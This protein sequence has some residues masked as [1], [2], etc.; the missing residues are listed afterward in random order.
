MPSADIDA[1]CLID[2]L[3]SGH[4]EAILQACGYT[5]YL[6]VAVQSEVLYIRQ[7]D[8]AQAGKL[9]LVE[10]DLNPLLKSGALSLC[11][12]YNDQEMDRF[13]QY[14]TQFRSDG[15]A[16][17]VALAESRGWTI[18]TDDRKAIRIAQQAGLSVISCPQIVK[19]WT[20]LTNPDKAIL[21]RALKDIEIFAQFRPNPSLPEYQWWVDNVS[22]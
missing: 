14:A 2:L 7:P 3:A 10:V 4:A 1:C 18:A 17:C 21:A 5:W 16:M 6:P 13:T 19:K 12:P 9:V 20:D 22:P 11:Q 8:P 15:E